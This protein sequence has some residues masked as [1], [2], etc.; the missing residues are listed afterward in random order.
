MA[1]RKKLLERELN[2]LGYPKA[3]ARVA[4]PVPDAGTN[5]QT[6]ETPH[7]KAEDTNQ[8]GD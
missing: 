7:P 6:G 1:V 4:T 8:H 5:Q 3:K 2:K